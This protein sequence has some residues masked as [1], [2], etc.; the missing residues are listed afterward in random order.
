MFTVS[1]IMKQQL[2]NKRFER[3][4]TIKADVNLLEIRGLRGE[5]RRFGWGEQ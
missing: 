2:K 4:I 5:S 3:N 1:I